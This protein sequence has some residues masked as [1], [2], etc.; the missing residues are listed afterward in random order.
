MDNKRKIDTSDESSS[1]KIKTEINEFNF[2][3]KEKLNSF[4]EY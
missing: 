2:D 1:K 4:N 3:G